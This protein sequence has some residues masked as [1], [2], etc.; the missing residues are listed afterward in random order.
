MPIVGD[1]RTVITELIAMLRR[2]P[3]TIEMMADWW[4]CLDG[5]RKTYPLSYG[6][7]ATAALS[8][9]I[10]LGGSP[11]GRRLR[12]RRLAP[13]VGRSSSD[14]KPR[15]WLNSGGLGTMGF[16]IRRPWADR[17]PGFPGLGDRRRRLL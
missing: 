3:G 11:G 9:V 12:R 4:A 14:T 1:V 17:P 5:V 10:Q 8:Y 7:Q 6:P 16:A 2:I 15:S 13:D